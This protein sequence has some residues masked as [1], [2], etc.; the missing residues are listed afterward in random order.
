MPIDHVP[1]YDLTYYLAAFD[2]HG[3]ERTDDPHGAGGSLSERLFHDIEAASGHRPFTDVFVFSHGW[4]GDVPAARDQYTR[5]AAT[6]AGCATDV[7][8]MKASRP[9]FRPL[10]VGLHWPSLPWGDESAIATASFGMTPGP[11]GQTAPGPGDAI[12]ALVEVYADRIVDT[13]TA[14]E[15]LRVILTSAMQ[16]AS[17]AF[18]PD[19]VRRAYRVLDDESGLGST[20]AA[21]DPGSDRR[22]FDAEERYQAAREADLASFGT[23][24]IGGILSPLRQLSF[25]KMKDRARTFGEGGAAHLVA[26]VQRAAGPEARLH[27]MGHS[28]GCIVMSGVLNGPGGAPVLAAPVHSLGLVQGALSLWSYCSDIPV[29]AGHPGYFR[30]VVERGMVAGPVITTQSRYDTAVG[31]FYPIA[32]GLA[33]QVAFGPD[34]P[35]FGGLGT[36]GVRGPG[37]DVV[38]LAMLPADGRYAFAPGRIYNLDASGFI[39]G[40]EGPSGAHSNIDR[41]PVAHALWAAAQTEVRRSRS[42]GGG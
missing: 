9:G 33:G 3:R 18:L 34:Y 13:P 14:R 6:M 38:N 21:G 19:D 36:F 40:G 16:D 26:S 39:N 37:C 30:A 8:R 1:G 17:P 28:F 32:A 11:A 5:W 20:G 2:K 10:L 15:A 22:P 23:S 24:G 42:T 25:W 12:E 29:A 41:P 31:R 35:R 4:K 7:D 27:L